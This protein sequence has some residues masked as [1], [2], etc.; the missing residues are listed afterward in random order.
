MPCVLI[1]NDQH[2]A[3]WSL[4]AQ[5]A[6]AAHTSLQN[7]ELVPPAHISAAFVS[8]STP[9]PIVD[10]C[11]VFTGDS[12]PVGYSRVS[13][14]R[15]FDG[16]PQAWGESAFLGIQAAFCTTHGLLQ[17]EWSVSGSFRGGWPAGSARDGFGHLAVARLGGNHDLKLP[18]ITNIALVH[19]PNG[20]SL[21]PGY[22]LARGWDPSTKSWAPCP[23][24]GRP[25]SRSHAPHLLESFLCFTR[26]EGAP[27]LD[28]GVV[29]PRGGSS[30]DVQL[31][32]RAAEL[33]PP[34]STAPP[35]HRGSTAGAGG[36]A[37]PAAAAALDGP[38]SRVR[39]SA[40]AARGRKSS[41]SFIHAAA[42]RPAS[43][44][45]VGTHAPTATTDDTSQVQSVP[46]PAI[47]ASRP[48]A[49]SVN[50]THSGGVFGGGIASVSADP[51]S[52]QVPPG[53]A[54][55][56][57][58]TDDAPATPPAPPNDDSPP[59]PVPAVQG[60]A[61]GWLT[62]N[63]P[64][65]MPPGWAPLSRSLC[66]EP[67]FL[68]AGQH[69]MMLAVL[70][71]MSHLAALATCV[72]PLGALSLPS[73]AWLPMPFTHAFQTGPHPLP[74]AAM[75]GLNPASSSRLPQRSE[76]TPT[77]NTPK[78]RAQ[79]TMLSPVQDE[80]TFGFGSRSASGNGVV[81]LSRAQSVYSP[82]H[83]RNG[84]S[85]DSGTPSAQQSPACS[86]VHSLPS[87]M[88]S[89][90]ALRWGS[91]AHVPHAVRA[92]TADSR[93]Q[94][95]PNG[96]LDSS[97]SDDD[98]A[99]QVHAVENVQAEMD[100]GQGGRG[101]GTSAGS[102]SPTGS[103][104]RRGSRMNSSGGAS[105]DDSSLDLRSLS[106]RLRQGGL[107]GG[108]S[109]G[110]AVPPPRSQ[111][112]LAAKLHL[113]AARSKLSDSPEL[114]L[115][116]A[117]AAV[118]I[119]A[120]WRQPGSTGRGRAATDG[121]SVVTA[122]DSFAAESQQASSQRPRLD[123]VQSMGRGTVAMPPP[124][125]GVPGGGLSA[126]VRMNI[127][128][129]VAG[130]ARSPAGISSPLALGMLTPVGGGS[131][132]RQGPRA[133]LHR[134]FTF[135][136]T[137]TADSPTSSDSGGLDF[138]PRIE[139]HTWNWLT[140]GQG[141]G[142][143][144]AAVL[145][146]LLPSL[147]VG[148]LPEETGWHASF[149][150]CPAS[151]AVTPLL[152]A[153]ASRHPRLVR[154]GLRGLVAV[155][156]AGMF[157]PAQ[158]Q[159]GTGVGG[160]RSGSQDNTLRASSVRELLAST[161]LVDVVAAVVADCL[162]PQLHCAE[163]LLAQLSHAVTSHAGILTKTQ[164]GDD[165]SGHSSE[166][167]FDDLEDAVHGGLDFDAEGGSTWQGLAASE[168]ADDEFVP[169]RT[170][171]E[172]VLFSL[173]GEL[174]ADG[175]GRPSD[176]QGDFKLGP[177]EFIFGGGSSAK[178]SAPAWTD[179]A[180]H[181]T[182][183]RVPLGLHPLTLHRLNSLHLRETQQHQERI[184]FLKSR[185]QR[186][187]ADAPSTVPHLQLELANSKRRNWRAQLSLRLWI[188]S[189]LDGLKLYAGA[190]SA[191]KYR[192]STQGE[193]GGAA[194]PKDPLVWLVPPV[195]T[196]EKVLVQM[197][198]DITAAHAS[199]SVA[200]CMDVHTTVTDVAARKARGS[201]RERPS[202]LAR[203]QSLPLTDSSALPS[204]VA[205]LA[206]LGGL[207]DETQGGAAASFRSPEV[208]VA[209]LFAVLCK[210]AAPREAESDT[211][212]R[213]P[214]ET[215]TPPRPAALQDAAGGRRQSLMRRTLALSCLRVAL[216]YAGSCRQLRWSPILVASV[217]A[218]VVPALLT[219]AGSTLSTNYALWHR[220]LNVTGTLW[221]M[222]R[223]Q[224][225]PELHLLLHAVAVRPLRC[226]SSTLSTARHQHEVLRRLRLWTG[227]EDG[228]D[229]Y[230]L[231]DLLSPFAHVA[232]QSRLLVGLAT[233]AAHLATCRGGAVATQAK[234]LLGAA[235][236][237][238]GGSSSE[239]RVLTAVSRAV[240]DHVLH[241]S[242][243]WGDSNEGP[244]RVTSVGVG[245]ELPVGGVSHAVP[246][247]DAASAQGGEGEE[248]PLAP[249]FG[250]AD[251]GRSH[252]EGVVGLTVQR[253]A[254]TWLA[255]LSGGLM[256]IAG[257][258]FLQGSPETAPQLARESLHATVSSAHHAAQDD[259]GFASSVSMRDSR[260]GSMSGGR[261]AHL[262]EGDGIRSARSGTVGARPRAVPALDSARTGVGSGHSRAAHSPT[263]HG[264]S[265]DG[266]GAKAPM[267]PPAQQRPP[268]A[269]LTP[270][271][272]T[273]GSAARRMLHDAAA[274]RSQDLSA[275][276][277]LL[278][279]RRDSLVGTPGQQ[280]GGGPH[281]HRPRA[282]SEG[283]SA[284]ARGL[285]QLHRYAVWRDDVSA[286]AAA[287]G[288]QKGNAG[289]GVAA[290][291]A[292]GALDLHGPPADTV[293]WLRLAGA[294]LGEEAVGDF[295]GDGG[296]T[297]SD[298]KRISAVCRLY[299][300]GMDFRARPLLDAMRHM[301]LQG[302]FRLPGEGQKIVRLTEMLAAVFYEA[303]RLQLSVQDEEALMQFAHLTAE[304]EHVK[305]AERERRVAERRAREAARAAAPTPASEPE[306]D[307]TNVASIALSYKDAHRGAPGDGARARRG[308]MAA[309]P[310][311]PTISPSRAGADGRIEA[312]HEDTILLL[313]NAVLQLNS[314]LDNPNAQK[315]EG[316]TGPD[317]GSL[318]FFV[319]NL[320]GN[321]YGNDF[322]REFLAVL[323]NSVKR[324]P[325]RMNVA[326]G[327]PLAGSA[328]SA[329]AA[330]AA[331]VDAMNQR[332]KRSRQA[333]Q[334][335]RHNTP[336]QEVWRGADVLSV[337]HPSAHRCLAALRSYHS[338]M[339][340]P[341]LGTAFTAWSS[342]NLPPAVP[343]QMRSDAIARCSR[344]FVHLRRKR[345][346][347]VLR[348][349]AQ[350]LWAPCLNTARRVLLPDTPPHLMDWM[351]PRRDIDIV[352]SA[353]SIL[354]AL[355]ITAMFTAQPEAVEAAADVLA[356]VQDATVF[357]GAFRS[358][359][360]GRGKAK[361]EPWYTA[362]T[363]VVAQW[364]AAAPS[365]ADVTHSAAGSTDS[366]AAPSPPRGAVA[367]VDSAPSSP[368]GHRRSA[369]L[370]GTSR[371]R[372]GGRL[373][374]GDAFAAPLDMDSIAAAAG[375]PAATDPDAA[376][377]MQGGY[378]PLGGALGGGSQTPMR[379]LQ[380]KQKH[381]AFQGSPGR[382]G[383]AAGL[384]AFTLPTA[385]LN[386]SQ[387]QPSAEWGSG[388]ARFGG[389]SGGGVSF[390]GSD[391]HA[392]S[393]NDS[394]LVETV[395]TA[396]AEVS[397]AVQSIQA[398]AEGDAERTNL[399]ATA[400]RFEREFRA[401]LTSKA[402]TGRRVV[403][404]G[405]VTKVNKGG[406]GGLK[407]YR[408]FLFSD[409][410]VYADVQGFGRS[411]LQCHNAI[412][413]QMCEVEDDPDA[414]AQR[415]MV[416]SFALHNPMKTLYLVGASPSETRIWRS[417]LRAAIVRLAQEGDAEMNAPLS[418][419]STPLSTPLQAGGEAAGSGLPVQITHGSSSMA[420]ALA[421]GGGVGPYALPEP[422]QVHAHMQAEPEETLQPQQGRGATEE[423]G[424]AAGRP[425][426]RRPS[427]AEAI[428][429]QG[430]A[431][432][433]V[434]LL[435]WCCLHKSALEEGSAVSFP[436]LVER[437]PGAS[438]LR[439][440]LQQLGRG[441]AAVFR[442]AAVY[443]G[444][445]TRFGGALHL[446]APFSV[447]FLQGDASPAHVGPAGA[448]ALFPHSA[449]VYAFESSA[450]L[451][452]ASLHKCSP[453][454]R[455]WCSALWRC[456]IRPL[457]MRSSA[458][459]AQV[460][461]SIQAAPGS[462]GWL[463]AAALAYVGQLRLS[464]Q[465]AMRELVLLACTCGDAGVEEGVLCLLQELHDAV[466]G[467]AASRTTVV[468]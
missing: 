114:Q 320:A 241:P 308:A 122:L 391:G 303:N 343:S 378:D 98:I 148:H 192:A 399:I 139:T 215:G 101:G 103:P 381:V 377:G 290:L 73:D 313:A 59:R 347:L 105:V 27:I 464:R 301:L 367:F 2:L 341:S 263:R 24:G 48:R 50:R 209:V 28:V 71:D 379:A 35:R 436:T 414:L 123:S 67:I 10:I 203:G 432:P 161:H 165:Y 92:G 119:S 309:P 350:D 60:G 210:L 4:F 337:L 280:G 226:V 380:S 37:A 54:R 393:G 299:L 112:D 385:A 163:D 245:G 458:D 267:T 20:E 104:L 224:C 416:P 315:K 455:L 371:S 402:A 113:T 31:A 227:L 129:T 79:G 170:P 145:K 29:L 244:A 72:R 390:P 7:H 228:L 56:R 326:P 188:V 107:A 435:R 298:A 421:R 467:A 42:T 82:A 449:L 130:G 285:L 43:T 294:E 120:G 236:G 447:L 63:L 204:S 208:D 276:V 65:P 196:S 106:F 152:L 85:V 446:T 142:G 430:S 87:H 195:A 307:R 316:S 223:V 325:L 74:P 339:C 443:I 291:A 116:P 405:A 373:S 387:G 274:K 108:A 328:P 441:G 128:K 220:L 137:P 353:L 53:K 78:G 266:G 1:S 324:H 426:K 39:S 311:K 132:Q 356:S 197:L 257:T 126:D 254:V 178:L 61:R 327:K 51:A 167:L 180:S 219:T 146:P 91:R 121:P 9:A 155:L 13:S 359:K 305:L 250:P 88:H 401:V 362:V 389:A 314:T 222:F 149:L 90:P 444:C 153:V 143:E 62:A 136:K 115:P 396:V 211:V 198:G 176:P 32:T 354:K 68:R 319:G 44:A 395:L 205:A 94:N 259:D 93:M 109:G 442:N 423:G 342:L 439:R 47:P 382:Q 331:L 159:Q 452:R 157:L 268:P 45:G 410:V 144:D 174:E 374:G 217:R 323:Y 296:K 183:G 189:V 286:K 468:V 454:V 278:G 424:G 156:R 235:G 459:I 225:A 66:D 366:S 392:P 240:H 335:S 131:P 16:L 160:T 460:H 345:S 360:A 310:S 181:A 184:T 233:A 321:D 173:R 134:T 260:A 22:K 154:A 355:L 69:P 322:P 247:V 358:L 86:P 138:A 190:I 186:A 96:L 440:V 300:H 262:G 456:A 83:G 238:G 289:K 264:A 269:T 418:A 75:G 448:P 11:L 351:D 158:V 422:L 388:R 336:L 434:A 14:R 357:A 8:A 406:Q 55:A 80:P 383:A 400:A 375:L 243:V 283:D 124:P 372:R 287:V 162:E 23:L 370:A 175:A 330:Q 232:P 297:D 46:P 317:F 302:G 52:P 207:V 428:P 111:D 338:G 412:P 340:A 81:A 135:S 191:A 433:A 179:K 133:P 182:A 425:Q 177:V 413:L 272:K 141:L 466:P 89:R 306:L 171:A 445:K 5:I 202:S 407:S 102:C 252:L 187:S 239:S 261:E 242:G 265:G 275:A 213:A 18:P 417:K 344:S 450:D 462:D 461:A 368:G 431:V 21:P 38:R 363:S 172:E 168:G 346:P 420:A 386:S 3:P 117:G 194:P 415:G 408:M 150:A 100:A 221:S 212:P 166:V 258:V 304:Y 164:A 97:E 249:L 397:L 318:D 41:F 333:A 147:E 293:L 25:P 12:L 231:G 17:V 206:R 270:S 15:C 292:A 77:Q 229:M 57:T 230:L 419:S 40:L 199:P 36:V 409:L 110:R 282:G 218:I 58:G 140:L 394:M 429:M 246:F 279:R 288:R 284:L 214:W 169:A 273:T 457:H 19:L 453:S 329:K 253:E 151:A 70:K 277:H 26:K 64:E 465:D 365:P 76:S 248:N 125:L 34:I 384:E 185:I 463:H 200:L 33:A 427:K 99:G 361:K 349:A 95:T 332:N 403:Y 127:G 312:N 237:E 30:S 295:L 271:G 334:W 281:G 352:R 451:L 398:A 364:R 216:Q 376:F 255:K 193:E 438:P 118:P 256:D 234:Q 404:E 84:E 369:T 251:V 348:A 6:D 437:L 49:E 201:P 411:K